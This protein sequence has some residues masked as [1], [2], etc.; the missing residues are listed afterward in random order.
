VERARWARARS[1]TDEREVVES[2]ADSR[3]G[4]RAGSRLAGSGKTRGRRTR[5][6]DPGECMR[7]MSARGPRAAIERLRCLGASD[8][9]VADD[10]F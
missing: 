1:A 5:P 4:R 9:V 3:I 10:S 7:D 2:V 6:G 8:C